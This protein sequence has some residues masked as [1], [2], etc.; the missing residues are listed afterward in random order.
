MHGLPNLKISWGVYECKYERKYVALKDGLA[1][2]LSSRL[3]KDFDQLSNYWVYK[4]TVCPLQGK[5]KIF[6]FYVG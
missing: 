1:C 6:P 2:V 3:W 4:N 5:Y